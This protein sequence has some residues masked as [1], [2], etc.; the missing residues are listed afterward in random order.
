[1]RSRRLVALAAGACAL[2]LACATGPVQA[3]VR[4]ITYQRW[5]AGFVAWAPPGQRVTAAAATVVLPAAATV[6]GSAW[7]SVWT[8]IGLDPGPGQA[9]VQA[10]VAM[11]WDGRGW[12]VVA[13]W[14][15]A[16]PRTPTP[17]IPL[18]LTLAPGDPVAIRVALIPGHR[19]RWR[20]SVEDL[21]TGGRAEATCTAAS[22]ED[23]AGWLVEDPSGPK[24]Y[25]PFADPARVRFV[26]AEVAVDGGPLRPV[27]AGWVRPVLR[28]PDGPARDQGP[29]SPWPG[30]LGGFVV[31]DL[32]TPSWR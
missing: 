15:V 3:A 1:M 2:G 24:G 22:P 10:G 25:L 23:S 32:P 21:R 5:G 14:W 13:P 28:V 16:E 20:F 17:P 19:R 26:A 31:A 11:R 9:L 27:P 12:D 8:G 4:A 29:L 18:D 7:L 6:R 30:P